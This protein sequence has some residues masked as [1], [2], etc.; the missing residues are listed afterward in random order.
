MFTE[1][2]R[3]YKEKMEELESHT[4]I[5]KSRIQEIEE[6]IKNVNSL[7]IQGIGA[8][9]ALRELGQEMGYI[10]END[11]PIPVKNDKPIPAFDEDAEVAQTNLTEEDMINQKECCE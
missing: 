7:K 4:Q 6:E 2:I 3:K 10:D 8:I 9:R 1:K 11:E 5:L